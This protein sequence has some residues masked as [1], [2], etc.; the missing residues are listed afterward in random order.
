MT[1]A[2]L[3]RQ[4][5]G[6]TANDVANLIEGTVGSSGVMADLTS[7]TPII[8]RDAGSFTGGSPVLNYSFIG[9]KVGIL[10]ASFITLN[11]TAADSQ[12][13]TLSLP[14]IGTFFKVH[15][16]GVGTNATTYEHI[17]GILNAGKLSFARENFALWTVAGA[18]KTA[19]VGGI[20]QLT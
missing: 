7:F 10:S 6:W 8:T 17:V 4:A 20:F 2:N 14:S 16:I 18:N 13:I 5:S 19:E 11:C 9:P 3:I 1:Y 15:M 12:Y